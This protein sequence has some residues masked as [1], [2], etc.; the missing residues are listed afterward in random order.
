MWSM[1]LQMHPWVFLSQGEISYKHFLLT[2]KSLETLK[3]L[4]EILMSVFLKSIDKRL[5]LS[6][7]W[8][9]LFQSMKLPSHASFILAYCLLSV[10]W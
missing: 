4:L 2:V 5:C 7:F 8:K 3:E 9:S 6:L 10:A 1:I